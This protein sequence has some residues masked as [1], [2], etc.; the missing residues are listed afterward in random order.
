MPS[1]L[2]G[3]TPRAGDAIGGGKLAAHVELD[4]A[5]Q[6]DDGLGMTAIF[7]ERVFESLRAVDEQAAIAAVLL[8]GDPVAAAVLANKDDRRCRAVR[9][10]FD[11]LHVGIPS[12]DE[13]CLFPKGGT[14]PSPVVMRMFGSVPSAG[15]GLTHALNIFR[16]GYEFESGN[17]AIS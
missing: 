10:R 15:R 17:T 12:D 7:K 11:E 8:L 5:R 6:L 9:W 3:D 1:G 13:Q 14:F 4:F 2:S 16:S